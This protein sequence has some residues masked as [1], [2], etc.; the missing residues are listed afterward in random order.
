MTSISTESK[1]S[2]GLVIAMLA[3]AWAI[4]TYS[5]DVEA[6]VATEKAERQRLEERVSWVIVNSNA[7]QKKIDSID[8]NVR[9]NGQ[10]LARIVAYM[11]GSKDANQKNQSN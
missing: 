8:K 5:R 1:I 2:V 6:M 11:E 10:K 3:G 9:E 7:Q 4:W